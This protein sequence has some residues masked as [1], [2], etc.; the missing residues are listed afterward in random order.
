MG[1]AIAAIEA[2]GATIVRA[3]IPTE[4]WIGGP[5]TEMAILNRNPESPGRYEPARRPIVFVYE[6]KHDLNAYLR[7]WL[8]D[9]HAGGTPIR[10]LADIIAFN[11]A[12]ADRALALRPGHLSRRRGDGA[13]I[14]RSWNTAPPAPP[15]CAPAGPWGSMRIWT[16][17][18]ST[19]CCFP[20][21]PEPRSP[22]RPAI[23]ASRCRPGLSAGSARPAYP[24]GVDIHR[25]RLERAGI[26]APGLC[27]RAGDAGAAPAAG[28]PSLG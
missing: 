17:T 6:L 10:T 11:R 2:C 9:A 26:A 1:Q 15:I 22:R 18:V 14:C 27:L 3:N 13:A 23:R 5:G 16:G 7:D 4:G 28:L 25:P 21:Q 19:R 20:A 24:F 12:N 8:P